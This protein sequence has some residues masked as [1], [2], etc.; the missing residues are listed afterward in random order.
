MNRAVWILLKEKLNLLEH[1]DAVQ[2]FFFLHDEGF[3]RSLALHFLDSVSNT[4]E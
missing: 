4:W 3:A 2:H 1:F